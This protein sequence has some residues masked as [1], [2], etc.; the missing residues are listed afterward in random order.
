MSVVTFDVAHSVV[1]R[2]MNSCPKSNS[3]EFENEIFYTKQFENFNFFLGNY[4]STDLASIRL[5]FVDS[6]YIN[7]ASFGGLIFK[8][9]DALQTES[10]NIN[11]S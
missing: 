8:E 7:N 9:A 11:R 3:P 5:P 1:T 4:S 10:S 6:F 2:F